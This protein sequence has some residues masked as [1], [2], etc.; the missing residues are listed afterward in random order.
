MNG[1]VKEMKRIDPDTIEKLLVRVQKPARYMGREL[2]VIV[3]NDARF[4]MALSYPDLYEVGMSNNGLR[5]LYDVVNAMPDAAC[6]RV[7]AVSDDFARALREDG[8]PL[9]TLETYTPLGGLDALGFNLSHELLCTNVLQI[10]DLGGIPL[11]RIERGEGMP[12][13][14]A[15]GEAASN[16]FP[17]GDFIDAFFIG[18]GEEGIRDI[19]TVLAGAKT[20]GLNRGESI[21]R[22]GEIPGVLLP[23]WYDGGVPGPTVK[24]RVYRGAALLDPVKPLVPG[25]RIAQERI[26]VEATRGCANFCNFCHAGFY[27]LP[28]R[29]HDHGAVAD[30]I[31]EIARNT[32]YNEVTLSSLSISDYPYLAALINRVL[33]DL[34]A[35]GI[36]VSFPSLRVDTATLPLIEQVSE[37]RR[38]SLT[39]AVESASEQVRARANKRIFI[40][41][42]VEIVRH[43]YDRGWKVI[44]LYFMIG[45]PGCEEYDEAG[46]IISLLK[47]IHRVGGR[48]LDINVTVSPFVPK[49]HTP[50]QRE[51]QRGRDYFEDTVRRIKRALP[52]SISIKN[53]DVE[54]SIIEGVLAR[55]DSRLGA[56]IE[57]SYR[58]GCRFDSWD[59]Y[60]RYDI[61][62]RNLDGMLPGWEERLG[63]RLEGPL[64]W[65]FVETGFEKLVEKRAEA[66][67]ACVPL[68]D[69]APRRREAIDAG[70]LE[71]A[72]RSFE[73]RYAVTG[74]IR[75][76]FTRTGMMRFIPHIDFMEIV[77]RALRMAGA[78]VAMSQGFNKRERVSAGF[79]TPV[80]IESEAELVDVELCG[81]VGDGFMARLNAS[82]PEGITAAGFRPIEDKTSLMAMT[83]VIEYRVTAAAG[84]AALIKGLDAG[85]EFRK[86]G[87]KSD[88]AVP[89][90]A[91]VHSYAKEDGQTVILCLFAGSEDSIRID[92]AVKTLLG[93]GDNALQGMRMVKTNQYRVVDGKL[94]KIE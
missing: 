40:D 92:D 42:L 63:G 79:P 20:A 87:K 12:I 17:M 55:G 13:I 66:S 90:D 19:V 73:G 21:D 10:L 26:V 64:P 69:R 94:A 38:A 4:R 14:I 11:R 15:G 25:I 5:I 27:D 78:P 54:A 30:R 18:D 81:G 3:K 93:G 32:G 22:I 49:P 35:M 2:N 89:F 82:L 33:S 85:P 76:R 75:V 67:A 71:A 51:R 23:S 1:A 60:F 24:K 62:R 6:E 29:C 59:E 68:R 31:L 43:V 41:D 28:Y 44:K 72:R 80:G 58:D 52:R 48:R 37:L 88:R 34:T 56:V 57:K 84:S 77:K 16:P 46:D 61:W 7:F 74:K 9:Y 39:F 65:R 47:N 53:H 36:S 8:V 45:L 50:F 70:R 86:H 83:G 91:V